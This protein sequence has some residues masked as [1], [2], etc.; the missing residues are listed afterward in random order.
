MKHCCVKPG[1]LVWWEYTRL[2]QLCKSLDAALSD[3]EVR[4]HPP[5]LFRLP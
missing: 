1:R 2:C 5:D 3:W 4:V